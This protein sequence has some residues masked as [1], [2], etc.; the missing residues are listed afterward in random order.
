MK[1][2]TLLAH[3]KHLDIWFDEDGRLDW[4]G[5][6]KQRALKDAEIKSFEDKYHG[7]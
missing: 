2:Y 3:L 7:V 1:A 6:D 4:S 5:D